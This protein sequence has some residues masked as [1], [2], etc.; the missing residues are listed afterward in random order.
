MYQ[1][2]SLGCA[3]FETILLYIATAI[4]CRIC[5]NAFQWICKPTT[6]DFI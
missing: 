2:E 1:Q 4:M 5:R 3:Q 6:A